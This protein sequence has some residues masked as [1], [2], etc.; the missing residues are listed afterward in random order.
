MSPIEQTAHRDFPSAFQ[1]PEPGKCQRR[2]KFS[3]NAIRRS[4]EF[5]RKSLGFLLSFIIRKIVAVFE[6]GVT[7]FVCQRM[8]AAVRRKSRIVVQRDGDDTA[9]QRHEETVQFVGLKI[10]LQ[11]DDSVR[12]KQSGQVV[13]RA[14]SNLPMGTD[15]FRHFR[16]SSA[17]ARN[18]IGTEIVVTEQFDDIQ[19]SGPHFSLDPHPD[20]GQEE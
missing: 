11:H 9:R 20:G 12:F 7:A 15:G 17:L 1:L 10:E 6:Q 13:Y 3:G 18:N 19:R 5:R 2:L 16:R 4:K 8:A 14:W